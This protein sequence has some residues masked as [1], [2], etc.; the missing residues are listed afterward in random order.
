MTVEKGQAIAF[1]ND[2]PHASGVNRT[3]KSV[4]HLFAYIVSNTGD[5]PSGSVFP[6]SKGNKKKLKVAR[7]ND[8]SLQEG[9]TCRRIARKP[10]FY[11][12]YSIW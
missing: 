2:F 12:Y 9:K 4:Y 10:D 6:L 5:F 1:T 8:V 11:G 7:E 3:N